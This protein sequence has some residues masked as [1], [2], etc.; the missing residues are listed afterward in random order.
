MSEVIVYFIQCHITSSFI[1]TVPRVLL[2]TKVQ[3]LC[4]HSETIPDHYV[5]SVRIRS[6][7][8]PNAGNEDWINSEYGHFLPSGYYCKSKQTSYIAELLEVDASIY[9][10]NSQGDT[11]NKYVKQK[12][13]KKNV[14]TIFD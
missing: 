8:V 12:Y 10:G 3:I 2:I 6:Y 1:V 9:Y 7:S 14:K 5:K 11:R 13:E 4:Y